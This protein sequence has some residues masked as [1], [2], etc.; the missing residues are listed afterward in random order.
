MPA[1]NPNKEHQNSSSNMENIYFY[2]EWYIKS[3]LDLYQK[4]ESR[5]LATLAFSGV[6][7]KIVSDSSVVKFIDCF[8]CYTCYALKVIS[9]IGVITAII[10]LVS[11]I[12]F[13]LKVSTVAPKEFVE[14]YEWFYETKEELE[15]FI[16]LQ[17]AK[18][19]DEIQQRLNEKG[20]SLNIALILLMIAGIA[21]AVENIIAIFYG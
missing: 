11:T 16:F 18:M 12:R 14:N 2:T 20:Y 15:K 1:I 21:Y 7:L 6:T 5:I 19:D 13:K 4:L 17:W 3:R 8:P 9:C 10:I